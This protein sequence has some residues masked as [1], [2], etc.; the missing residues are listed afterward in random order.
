M[1]TVTT[2]HFVIT[3]RRPHPEG[4]EPA[5]VQEFDAAHMDG[6]GSDSRYGFRGYIF[7]DKHGHPVAEL[8]FR[9]C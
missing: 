6:F 7:R 5:W 8:R 2:S 3:H 9:G 4:T 1:R